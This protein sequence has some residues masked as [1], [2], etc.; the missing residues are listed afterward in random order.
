MKPYIGTKLINAKPM[1]RQAYNDFRNWPLPI[2]ENGDDPGFLVE[3]VDGGKANTPQYAGYVS[4]S[5]ADVFGRAY[6]PLPDLAPEQLA[7][8]APHQQR[9]VIEKAE[10]DEKLAKLAA[11]MNTQRF[12][13]LPIDEFARLT[14]QFTCMVEYS[15]V[16]GE[17]IA[18]F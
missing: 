10:L 18:A 11:F 17:R 1:T 7:A 5:P 15:A 3:Y 8:L 12:T 16:L 13:A 6:R 4:W 9:V 2:D 14:R